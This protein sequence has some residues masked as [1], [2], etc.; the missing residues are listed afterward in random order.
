MVNGFLAWLA[1]FNDC[2]KSSPVDISDSLDFM[3]KLKCMT[4]NTSKGYE[5]IF[6]KQF[7]LVTHPEQELRDE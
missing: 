7:L 6:S 1:G 2:R 4:V 3:V 5:H